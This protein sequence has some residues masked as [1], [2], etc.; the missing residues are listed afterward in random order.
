MVLSLKI[1]I[2]N[3]QVIDGT[4]APGYDADVLINGDKIEKIAKDISDDDAE[5]IDAS[6]RVVTP[7]LLTFIITVILTLLI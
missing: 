3:G 6:G 1:L 7:G 5:V 4:G 2:K